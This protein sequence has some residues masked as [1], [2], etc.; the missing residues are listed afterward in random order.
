MGKRRMLRAGRRT[1]MV[2]ALLALAIGIFG[3]PAGGADPNATYSVWTATRAQ[4]AGD[5]QPKAFRSYELDQDA[6][7]AI[8]SQA[9]R[10]R[11]AAA[12]NAPLVLSLPGPGGFPQR[13]AIQ[14]SPI[15]QA[16][17]AARAS[18]DPHLRRQRH[19]RSGG[20]DSRR[21]QP[22][23]LPRLDPLA[24]GQL[25]HRPVRAPDDSVYVELLR[26]RPP[27]RPGRAVRSSEGDDEE[28]TAAAVELDQ[29][30]R[31]VRGRHAAHLPARARHRPVVLDLLRR[32]GERDRGEGRA[33]QPRR[34]GLRGRDRDPARPDRRHR[35]DEPEHGRARRSGRTG[36]A[37]RRRASRPRSSRCLQ[38]RSAATGSCSARSSARPTTTSAT[39]ASARTAAASPASASSAAT[40]RR[41]AAPASRPRWAT[42][43]PSTTWRT[44]WATSSPATTPSTARS[45]N[46]SGGNRNAAT[47]VEPGSGSSIMAY[48]GICQQDDLQPHSDP[49]WSQRSF[50][51]ITTYVTSA[52]PP[53][54]EVQ[55][56]VAARLR[57]HRLVQA[58]PRRRHV[59]DDHERNELHRS[60][61]PGRPPGRRRGPDGR[62]RRLR[63]HRLVHAEL[64]GHGHGSDRPRPEQHRG[65]DPECAPGRQRA[66]AG[67]ADRLQRHHAVVPDPGRTATRRR[68]SASAVSPSRTPTSPRRS[69]PCSARPASRRPAPGTGASRSRSAARW[70]TRTC[71]RSRSSTAPAPASPPCGRPP[72]AAAARRLARRRHRCRRRSDRRGLL[73]HVRR[74][75][76]GDGRRSDLGHERLRRHGRGPRD[77][78]GLAGDACA[79][80]LATVA[81][82]GGAARSTRPASRSR[83]AARS[84]S[85]T[86]TRSPSST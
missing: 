44:R 79:R 9:P 17:L 84:A 7:A 13:F 73:A 34:P 83:S 85:S 20:D 70:R 36:P 32:P 67:R 41:R 72:R 21:H 82:F 2:G 76:P 28:L 77:R 22:A 1:W 50:D 42:S 56:I 15:M 74:R 69:T 78:E 57:R 16:G 30:R 4:A 6:I 27:G 58:Q 38:Q 66:A 11:T 29:R 3:P 62:A 81:G 80:C 5:A 24:E 45:S 33:D 39:S 71:P 14:D 54:N 37:V 8:L 18:R 47:S 48:A 49:Y 61:D 75:P 40:A 31:P 35:Q 65:R 12:E 64:Q 86:S 63:R 60:R 10:E 25:V 46:C 59:G 68:S 55:T 23:R 53:I 19:R 26:A 51:E 52:R 43:T